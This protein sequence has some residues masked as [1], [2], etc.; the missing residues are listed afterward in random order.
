M[1][2]TPADARAALVL[3][4][5][6][7]LVLTRAAARMLER[8]AFVHLARSFSLSPARA[9]LL[10]PRGV[11]LDFEVFF[12]F[13][14]FFLSFFG[15]TR[16][17]SLRRF[18]RRRSSSESSLSSELEPDP[19]VELPEL[20]RRRLLRPPPPPSDSRLPRPPPRFAVLPPATERPEGSWKLV[21]LSSSALH[22]AVKDRQPER[23][24]LSRAQSPSRYASARAASHVP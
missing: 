22:A 15:V 18:L 11:F 13:G 20:E 8:R 1:E 16:P 10:P 7:L 6:E 24:S 4:E 19:P 2:Q 9:V 17:A 21:G 3:R 5:V 23:C 12:F 14:A